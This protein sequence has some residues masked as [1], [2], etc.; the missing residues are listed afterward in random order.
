MNELTIS[1]SV[2]SDITVSQI[3]KHAGFHQVD[4]CGRIII[5]ENW[6]TLANTHV[7]ISADDLLGV[8]FDH[9]HKKGGTPLE[10][11]KHWWHVEELAALR[12]IE[13][14]QIDGTKAK[15]PRLQ[16]A[17][18]IP[19]YVIEDV[20]EL[21]TNS[22]ITD[23]LNQNGLFEPA[24]QSFKELYY[25]T[26]DY[27]GHK[28]TFCAAACQNTKFG[29]QV[30]SKYFN[31]CIG[32][33]SITFLKNDNRRIAIFENQYRYLVWKKANVMANHSALILNTADSLY[34]AIKAA[35]SFPEIDLFFT[36]SP[37][38]HAATKNFINAL[39]YAVNHR[40]N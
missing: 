12:K 35:T 29:W 7:K 30:I 34:Q 39:P 40:V 32:K 4:T 27:N 9:H 2:E 26:I 19:H 11:V 16:V 18:K 33:E 24:Q 3:L 8:W 22:Y 28:K 31:G 23:F 38:G 1:R 14:L 37:S 13:L 5:Y 21:G 36:A 15:R 6:S 25:Y 10:L 20:R 17:V